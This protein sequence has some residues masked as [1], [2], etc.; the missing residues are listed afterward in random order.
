[1]PLPTG[2]QYAKLGSNL[3][4]L[5]G[6]CSAS[7]TPTGT[8]AAFPDLSENVPSQ[9]YLVAN[10]VQVLRSLLVQLQ[11]LQLPLSSQAAAPF[12]PMLREMEEFLAKS[13]APRAAFLNDPFA[14]RLIVV[15]KQVILA[16]RRDLSTPI[17]SPAKPKPE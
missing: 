11:E 5:R 2:Y 6:I 13:P 9:R 4:Y 17:V 16:A 7:L 15:A 8:L 3:E 12:H 14:Q 1:M 10:V